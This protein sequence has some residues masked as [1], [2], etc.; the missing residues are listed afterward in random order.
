MVLLSGAWV[1]WVAISMGAGFLGGTLA[2]GL[3]VLGWLLAES[4]YYQA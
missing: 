1:W 4:Y 2:V 3:V